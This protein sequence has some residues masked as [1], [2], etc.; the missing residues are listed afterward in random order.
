MSP[1]RLLLI[2]AALV[3]FAIDAFKL[4]ARCNFVS[5]GFAFLTASLLA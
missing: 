2:A 3:C 5:L 1:L 4:S